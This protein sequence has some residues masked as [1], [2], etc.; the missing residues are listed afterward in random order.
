MSILDCLGTTL[1]A[2]TLSPPG[3]HELVQFVREGR[4]KQESTLIGFGVKAPSWMAALVNSTMAHFLDYD[5]IH[6]KAKVHAG[7]AIV[8]PSFAVAER[9]GEVDGKK[10]ITAVVLGM[11][12][13]FR[14]S[15]AVPLR[16]RGFDRTSVYG[17]FGAAAAAGRIL[18]L[19]EGRLQNALGIAY[20][21]AAGN[22]QAAVEASLTKRLQIGFAGHAGVLSALL[23]ETGITGATNSLEGEFGF[24]RVYC[25]GD[26][27]PAVLTDQLGQRFEAAN[28]SFK[29]YP[30]GRG[31]HASIDAT[32]QMAREHDIQPEDVESVTAFKSA[33]AA[34]REGTPIERKRQPETVVEAQSSIPYTVAVALVKR[35]VGLRD[36]RPE[37]FRDPAVL[38]MA[39]KVIPQVYPEFGYSFH[40]GITEI[41][42]KGGKVY[43]KRIDKPSGNPD[44]PTPA[45][46]LIEKFTECASY[47]SK[48]LPE[49]NVRR[50]IE[51]VMDLERVGDM[52]A[53]MRLLG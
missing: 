11:D 4:G 23:A 40:P 27:D 24:F 9:A 12:I 43:S 2:S 8:A 48:P 29:P 15:L 20:S 28:L 25:G 1:A 42:T 6:E 38:R 37:S 45:E 46:A 7:S 33:V 22:A 39:Q 14:M 50:V 21:Q 31:T 52:A 19:D 36:F 16:V 49:E 5:D 53:I 3:G 34:K 32:L 51:M 41:R 26:Y 13:A 35:R 44:N 17:L 47:A 30:C 10:F 18:G